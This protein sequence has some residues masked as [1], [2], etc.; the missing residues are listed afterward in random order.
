MESG[1]M[2]GDPEISDAISDFF[3]MMTVPGSID[4]HSLKGS[5]RDAIR[6]LSTTWHYYRLQMTKMNSRKA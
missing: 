6:V 1:I 2:P 5:Q 3:L 4:F